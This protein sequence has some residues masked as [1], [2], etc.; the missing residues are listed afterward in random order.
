MADTNEKVYIANEE[1]SQRI[2]E[3]ATSANTNAAIA[4]NQ[5]T[6]AA[7]DA[8][9]IK[10]TVDGI[11]DNAI[12]AVTQATTAVTNSTAT[13]TSIGATNDTGGTSTTGTIFGKL[14]ALLANWTSTR[15]GYID[16]I[17]NSTY[18]LDKIKSTVDTVNT[19]VDTVDTVVDNI[20]TKVDSEIG[21]ISTMQTNIA[22]RVGA[23]GDTGG[24]TTG[25][26]LA[27]KLNALL[28]SW[29]STRA[30][31]ID[32]INTNAGRLTAV[33]ATKI[34]NIGATSDTDGSAT[35]GTV[36]G[37][38][39]GIFTNTS[40]ASS[41]ANSAKTA[42]ATNNTASKTGT[43]SQKE[44]YTHSLLENTT[45]GLSALKTAI[46][47]VNSGGQVTPQTKQFTQF[48]YGS[49]DCKSNNSVTITGSGRMVILSTSGAQGV[50]L[51]VDGGSQYALDTLIA[52]GN[53]EIYFNSKVEL[54]GYVGQ[55]SRV[56]QY[57]LQT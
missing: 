2:L 29:T 41:Y 20:Y 22:T 36:M 57:F 14:N 18:G 23:T 52:G 13:N 44:S 8:A 25:G 40:N 24:T 11:D 42:T 31:Y 21:D 43:L 4:A 53:L 37:K 7:S 46:G 15:A 35:A 26:S 48:V 45:Y 27:A 30:G 54:V 50:G 9:S 34:D 28:T 6:A 38:L 51:K 17:A 12:N 39:N 49:V 55:S 47:S 16:R 10:S 5:A 56:I 19:K 3:E 32:T 33:R 1:T